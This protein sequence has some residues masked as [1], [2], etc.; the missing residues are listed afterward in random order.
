[1]TTYSAVK[2]EHEKTEKQQQHRRWV[3]QSTSLHWRYA[4][5]KHKR[6]LNKNGETHFGNKK[7]PDMLA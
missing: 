5:T 7:T 6:E 2:Q 4:M 3:L 1:M